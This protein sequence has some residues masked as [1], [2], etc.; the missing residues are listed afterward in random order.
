LKK[1]EERKKKEEEK[2]KEDEK[3]KEEEKRLE[4]EAK[5]PKKFR[6]IPS[7]G[8]QNWSDLFFIMD[9]VSGSID[10]AEI[11]V[12]ISKTDD[13]VPILE[14][15]KKVDIHATKLDVTHGTL[16]VAYTEGGIIEQLLDLELS[17]SGGLKV[18]GWLEGPNGRV[19]LA[20][21]KVDEITGKKNLVFNI[22]MGSS[23]QLISAV[24]ARGRQLARLTNY[25]INLPQDLKARQKK[26]YGLN[27][28]PLAAILNSDRP[29]SLSFD[30]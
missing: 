4:E 8:F 27:N 13:L 1:E 7:S 29:L 16:S 11:L 26:K 15:E 21:H 28:V 22:A 6:P 20:Q 14:N 2:K 24:Y 19:E 9:V 12:F 17:L 10:I 25:A 3:R 23:Y 5:K 30:F 18:E